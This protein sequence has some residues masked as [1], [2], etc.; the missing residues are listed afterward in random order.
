M[1]D[2]IQRG[3]MVHY[4]LPPIDQ[5]SRY[6]LHMGLEHYLLVKFGE[7]KLYDLDKD[8]KVAACLLLS[9]DGTLR[10]HETY[11]LEKVNANQA[12]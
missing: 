12:T 6:D 5:R 10:W 7:G 2:K 8:G 1:P 3:D 4:K 11:R 9:V